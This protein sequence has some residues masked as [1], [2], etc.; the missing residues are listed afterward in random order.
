M[1]SFISFAR[2]RNRDATVDSICTGC[3]QTIASG[4]NE[5]NLAIAEESHSCDPNEKFDR[6]GE[7]SHYHRSALHLL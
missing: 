3:Y 1:T 4:Q 5:V 2:R 6:Q 7:T